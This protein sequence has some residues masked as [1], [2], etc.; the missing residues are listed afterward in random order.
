LG[1]AVYT[2]QRP[3]D[4]RFLMTTD[5]LE[6]KMAV[7]LNGR[8]AEHLFFGKIST[9]ASDDRVKAIEIARSMVTRYG[10]ARDLGQVAYETERGNFLGQPMEGG[11]R[12][13]SE[14][15]AREIDLVVKDLVDQAYMRAKCILDAQRSELEGLARLVLEKETL[16]AA[17]LPEP[18]ALREAA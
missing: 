8:A 12:R 15:T 10:M 4:D 7:T 2:L 13:F 11:G 14:Q 1:I 5:E 9:G 6:N 18:A 3:T 16:S 17:E